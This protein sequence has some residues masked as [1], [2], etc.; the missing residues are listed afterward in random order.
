MFSTLTSLGCALLSTQLFSVVA[1]GRSR[2]AKAVSYLVH[3]QAGTE[4]LGHSNANL[5]HEHMFPDGAVELLSVLFVTKM[6]TA[7]RNHPAN[8]Y[9][10]QPHSGMV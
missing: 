9:P 3:V 8:G 1:N 2:H 7:G 6:T 5:E 4:K 10:R